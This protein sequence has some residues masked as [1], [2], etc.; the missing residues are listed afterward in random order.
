M[1]VW[2]IRLFQTLFSE[3]L[4]GLEEAG[5]AAALKPG[6]HEILQ[7]GLKTDEGYSTGDS[8]VLR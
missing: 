1:L 3:V 8:G 6:P 4:G 2:I 7:D 5:L